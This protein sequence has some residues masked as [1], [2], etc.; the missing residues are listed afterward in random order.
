[1][2]LKI[3][4]HDSLLIQ[5]T[6]MLEEASVIK[7][8]EWKEAF[9][10]CLSAADFADTY[11]VRWDVK[12]M[13]NSL[14]WK[15]K[16]MSIDGLKNNPRGLYKEMRRLRRKSKGV[17]TKCYCDDALNKLGMCIPEHRV[18]LMLESAK[19][20]IPESL[21]SIQVRTD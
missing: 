18:A 20:T 1:M 16:R 5:M 13:A 2:E 3:I 11:S 4:E 6:K 14:Y 7:E 15:I 12:E 19:L 8:T 21:F 17:T 10:E 9:E